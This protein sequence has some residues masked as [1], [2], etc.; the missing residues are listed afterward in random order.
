MT[1]EQHDLSIEI[2]C[3]NLP[4]E[5]LADR[6]PVYLGIQKDDALIDAEPADAKRIVFRPVLE[7]RKH[8]DGTP[9][10]QGP[11]AHGPRDERF[12]YLVWSVQER[13]K[14]AQTFGRVKLH[15]NHIK[16]QDV[17]KAAGRKKPIKVTLPLTN[18]KGKPVMASVRSDAAEWNL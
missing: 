16:W 1:A 4:K 15:L 3:T 2:T 17:E 10:F 5:A 18:A 11:F 6:G 12:I 8:K 13:G 14:P 9:T 7:V